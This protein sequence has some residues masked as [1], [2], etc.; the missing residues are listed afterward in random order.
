MEFRRVEIDAAL[1]V[2]RE[3]VVLVAVPETFDDVDIFLGALIALGMLKVRGEAEIRGDVRAG[4]HNI[5]SGA[6]AGDMVQRCELARR[7]VR[8][9]IRRGGGRDKTD[10]RRERREGGPKRRR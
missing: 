10:M 4:G 9:L 6:A 7:R 5:P 1:P 3:G 8:L 2:A